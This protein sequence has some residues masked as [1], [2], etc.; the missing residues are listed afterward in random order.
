MVFQERRLDVFLL[1]G[2]RMIDEIIECITTVLALVFIALFYFLVYL[3]PI[4]IIAVVV[5]IAVIL[6]LSFIGGLCGFDFIGG[7]F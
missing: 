4:I 7:L 2:G 6:I 1:H 3:L 5:V